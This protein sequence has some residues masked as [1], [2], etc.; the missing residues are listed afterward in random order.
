MAANNSQKALWRG[1]GNV[2]TSGEEHSVPTFHYLVPTNIIM[3]HDDDRR[4]AVEPWSLLDAA[5]EL[6][7]S[8]D[9]GRRFLEQSPMLSMKLWRHERIVAPTSDGS[10]ITDRLEFQP[11]FAVTLVTWFIRT[12]FTHRH[13][14]LRRNLGAP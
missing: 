8:V 13:A 1:K 7:Q 11:R 10:T 9:S 12:T 4:L 5:E 2:L 14:I 3:G 6:G